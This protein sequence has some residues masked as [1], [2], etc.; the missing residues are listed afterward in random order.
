MSQGSHPARDRRG[1]L[2]RGALPLVVAASLLLAACGGSKD[3]EAAPDPAALAASRA[4][5]ASFLAKATFGPTDAAV[6]RLMSIGYAAWVDEQLAL[7]AASHR[8]SWDAAD[9]ALKAPP[10]AGAGGWPTCW[11]A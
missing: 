6:D 9:A 1:H 11:S 3:D 8:T 5:A 7:P 2:W 4:E 10:T